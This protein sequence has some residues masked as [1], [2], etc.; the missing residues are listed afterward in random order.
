MGVRPIRTPAFFA[1]SRPSLVLAFISSRSNSANPPKTASISQP[2]WS[3]SV[4]PRL[5]HGF[6]KAALVG[7]R[8]DGGQQID[9]G[10]VHAVQSRAFWKGF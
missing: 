5:G 9:R 10:A 8:L 7:D 1:L 4:G 3:R 6:E 2:R